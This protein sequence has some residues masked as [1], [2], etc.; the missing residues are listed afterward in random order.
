MSHKQDRLLEWQDYHAALKTYIT[1]PTDRAGQIA[2]RILLGQM[3]EK[4]LDLPL[5]SGFF[6]LSR[7]MMSKAKYI[8]H[9]Y[10]TFLIQMHLCKQKEYFPT[11]FNDSYMK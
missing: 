4:C 7:E 1:S 9:F 6:N 11:H 10:S 2:C 5:S 3:T 8:I